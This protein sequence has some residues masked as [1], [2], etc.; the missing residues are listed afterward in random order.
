[1]SDGNW[2]RRYDGAD[3]KV[4]FPEIGALIGYF[5]KWSLVFNEQHHAYSLEATLGY[6]N[7]KL[8]DNTDYERRIELEQG[9][10]RRLR[11]ESGDTIVL[12]GTDLKMEKV[13]FT[14]INEE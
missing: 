7:H 2:V 9:F 13:T 1:M 11:I 12:N 10:G 14:R 6:V 4:T 3:G 5:V 8:W